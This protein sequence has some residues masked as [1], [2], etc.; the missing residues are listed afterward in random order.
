MSSRGFWKPLRW[1]P[2]S[3]EPQF[4]LRTAG[5]LVVLLA[6]FCAILFLPT[7]RARGLAHDACSEAGASLDYFPGATSQA[8][9]RRFHRYASFLSQVGE[10]SLSCVTRAPVYRFVLDRSFQGPISVRVERRGDAWHLVA[11]ERVSMERETSRTRRVAR[12][13]TREQG[14]RFEQAL[15]RADLFDAPARPWVDGR[16]GA[17]WVVELRDLDRYRLHEEWSPHEGPVR[18][19]GGVLLSLTGWRFEPR[20]VY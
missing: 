14:H 20:D 8:Q 13:L 9:D 4:K 12:A 18:E 7:L 3:A 6:A 16:D 15:A 17:D 11:V 2:R 1:G 19:F 10:P 5:I